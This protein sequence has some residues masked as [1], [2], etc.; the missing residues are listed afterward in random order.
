[1]N[2]INKV[3]THPIS[4][5]RVFPTSLYIYI[6]YSLVENLKESALVKVRT[7]AITLSSLKCE[8]Y[9]GIDR[10]DYACESMI[11]F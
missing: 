10:K 5:G 8:V 11:F 7:S 9:Y 4:H 3:N 6:K 1:M 2:L